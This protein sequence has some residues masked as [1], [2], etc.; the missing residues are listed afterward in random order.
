MTL[1]SHFTS[2]YVLISEGSERDFHTL[3]FAA[4]LFVTAKVWSHHACPLVDGWKSKYSICIHQ[5]VVQSLSCVRLFVS[6]WTAARQAS[7]SRHYLPE[8]A[9]THI[10]WAGDAYLILVT[11]LFSCP[12]SFPGFWS[13]SMSQLF[14]PGAQI[15]A[16][17]SASVPPMNVQVWFPSGLTGLISLQSKGLSRV[18]F[19]TRH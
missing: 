10:H 5:N 2:G 3:I 16:S 14:A 11:L 13:F 15:G 12:Q 18:F 1:S 7:L 9:Q 8:L 4:A 17:P 6:P 19:S